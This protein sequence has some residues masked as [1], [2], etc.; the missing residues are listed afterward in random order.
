MYM[1]DKQIWLKMPL[2]NGTHCKDHRIYRCHWWWDV[3]IL[4]GPTF[5]NTLET[6]TRTNITS[7][8]ASLNRGLGMA[9]KINALQKVEP[10]GA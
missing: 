9:K 10:L 1:Y 7:T 8:W 6:Q 2:D 5:Q 4:G 3:Q